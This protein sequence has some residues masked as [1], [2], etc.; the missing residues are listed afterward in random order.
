MIVWLAEHHV[1]QEDTTILGIF[2]T[3][4]L[5]EKACDEHKATAAQ[6][7]DFE[8]WVTKWHV[9]GHPLERAQRA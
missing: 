3:R 6:C 4:E 8:W 9:D 5:A 2:S 7:C 1:I